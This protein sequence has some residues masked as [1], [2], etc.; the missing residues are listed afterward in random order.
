MQ[1]TL[2]L[3]FPLDVAGEGPVR[4][5]EVAPSRRFTNDGRFDLRGAALPDGR[6]TGGG[7][8]A[9]IEE[10]TVHMVGVADEEFGVLPEP[11]VDAD[12]RAGVID[13]DVA[14]DV[15]FEHRRFHVPGQANP[16]KRR[17]AACPANGA[18]IVG[19]ENF[20]SVPAAHVLVHEHVIDQIV[21]ID[22]FLDGLPFFRRFQ[23]G[24]GEVLHGVPGIERAVEDFGGGGSPVDDVVFLFR[25]AKMRDAEVG[26]RGISTGL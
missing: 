8:H 11:R 14:G 3:G 12:E 17:L 16:G 9:M 13:V 5:P 22:V 19:I 6:S 18:H 7:E 25:A 15:D 1:E 2:P 20:R 10:V 4:T 23:A 21:D 26:A 24:I